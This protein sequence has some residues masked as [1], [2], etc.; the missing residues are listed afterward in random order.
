[1]KQHTAT[2]SF[3]QPLSL[4]LLPRCMRTLSSVIIIHSE[5]S[6]GLEGFGV[7]GFIMV[8]L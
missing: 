8:L 3:V 5:V 7:Y 6:R 1:M 4:P 2:L